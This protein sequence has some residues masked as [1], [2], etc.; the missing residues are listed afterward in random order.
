VHHCLATHAEEESEMGKDNL[1]KAHDEGQR[2]GAKGEYTGSLFSGRSHEEQQAYNE[3]HTHGEGTRDGAAG[4]YR[5]T[6]F[7][8]RS[9]EEQETYNKGYESSCKK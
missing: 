2:D 8:G 6:L 9:S 1:A 5:G 7:S 3:G 4:N